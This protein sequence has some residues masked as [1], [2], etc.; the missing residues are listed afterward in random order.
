LGGPVRAGGISGSFEGRFN[1]QP[2]HRICESMKRDT[3]WI[4]R[5]GLGDN[6]MRKLKQRKSAGL[7]L[8][9][10]V[11]GS[12]LIVLTVGATLDFLVRDTLQNR[13]TRQLVLAT[14]AARAMLEH[15]RSM[16]FETITTTYVPGQPTGPEDERHPLTAPNAFDVAGLEGVNG[17]P[18]GS[19]FVD[20]TNPQLL[21][22]TVTIT[23][24]N[25]RRTNSIS[26][27]S[28]MADRF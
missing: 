3:G 13:N 21:D 2:W 16:D 9:E 5:P 10:I 11:L 17:A 4:G 25:S 20:D 14:N 24:R 18:A 7:T 28:L 26:V 6:K 27:S 1:L 8:I 19:V 23:W 22:V 12:G 15:I